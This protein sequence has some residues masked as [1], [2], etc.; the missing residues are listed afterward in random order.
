MWIKKKGADF[1]DKTGPFFVLAAVGN[2]AWIFLWH[3]QYVALSLIPMLLLLA[4]LLLLYIR[5][6]IGNISVPR[7][8]QIFVN[9]P[10]SIYLG[11]ITVATIANITAVLVVAGWD[12]FGLSEVFYTVLVIAVAA[13]ITLLI[14]LKRGDVPYSLVVIWAYIGIIIKRLRMGDAPA[15]V[16]ATAICLSIVV[17]GAVIS[18]MRRKSWYAGKP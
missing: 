3:Y 1:L 4:S 8:E 10:V 2:I 9:L 7:S 5:L 16:I 17:L 11:W 13:I 18:L 14:L 6:G 12:G 15:V